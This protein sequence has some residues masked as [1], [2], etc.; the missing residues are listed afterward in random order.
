MAH[1]EDFCGSM[2]WWPSLRQQEGQLEKV[3]LM[4]PTSYLAHLK[5]LTLCRSLLNKMKWFLIYQCNTPSKPWDA[6]TSPL[7]HPART[8]ELVF[9]SVACHCSP[10]SASNFY[11]RL[12]LLH[13]VLCQIC[14]E[15]HYA[16]DPKYHAN[17][18]TCHVTRSLPTLTIVADWAE[19]AQHL[20][21]LSY[22]ATRI[23]F[24][25]GESFGHTA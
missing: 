11:A 16:S 6:K 3:L 7:F 17:Y 18:K 13:K 25:L 19:L 9:C 21:L 20:S 22:W 1:S 15:K 14:T 10:R 2:E 5:G 23:Q 24:V 8:V 4:C 12:T